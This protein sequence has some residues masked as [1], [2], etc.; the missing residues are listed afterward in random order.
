[1]QTVAQ[2][3][4]WPNGLSGISGGV[5]VRPQAARS[6]GERHFPR[7]T[8]GRL[9]W[10]TAHGHPDPLYILRKL[11]VRRRCGPGSRERFAYK[12]AGHGFRTFPWAGKM[13]N[14]DFELYQYMNHLESTSRHCLAII[15]LFRMYQVAQ[16]AKATTA[17][18]T[19]RLMRSC[20]A[21]TTGSSSNSPREASSQTRNS[22]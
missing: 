15:E 11:N 2:L 4:Q 14:S 7:G 21:K 3:V 6:A 8:S 1:M 19:A 13:Q 9:H 20:M 10:R 22:Q 5:P 17:T 16:S 18:P 12:H